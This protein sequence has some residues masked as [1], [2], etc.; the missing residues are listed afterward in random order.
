MF[1]PRQH[2]RRARS[3]LVV[4]FVV[5]VERLCACVENRLCVDVHVRFSHVFLSSSVCVSVVCMFSCA[6]V[7]T[8]GG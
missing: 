6:F 7:C 5:F 1:S 8:G 4:W 2:L 3:H